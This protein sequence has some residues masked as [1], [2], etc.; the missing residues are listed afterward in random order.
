LPGRRAEQ[1]LTSIFPARKQAQSGIRAMKTNVT[2]TMVH[3]PEA[4]ARGDLLQFRE[5]GR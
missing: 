3:R 1:L 5:H 2:G 4:S